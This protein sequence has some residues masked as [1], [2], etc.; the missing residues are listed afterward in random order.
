MAKR[1]KNE[2]S[3]DIICATATPEGAAALAVIRLSGKGSADLVERLME[4]GPGRLKG[5]RRKTGLLKQGSSVLDQVVALGWPEGSSYTGEEMVEIICHGVPEIVRSIMDC[6]MDRGARK[7]EPGE[8]TRRAYGSGRLSAWQVMA[9]SALWRSGDGPNNMVGNASAECEE[10]LRLIAEA[11]EKLEAEIEFQEEHSIGEDDSAI[12]ILESLNESMKNFRNRASEMETVSRVVL[13]GPVNSGKSTLFNVLAGMEKALVSDEPG[14][15]R[16]GSSCIVEMR[17]RRVLLC[18]SA[19]Y[20]GQGLDRK[21]YEAVIG[22]MEGT[23]KIV[24]LSVG[25]DEEPPEEILGKD[26][27]IIR[28]SSKSDLFENSD[29]THV[30]HTLRVSS[31]TGEGMGKLEEFISSFPGSM[32]VT[33][34]AKRIEKEVRDSLEYLLSGDYSLAAEHLAEAENELRAITARGDNVSLSVERAL[35][36][37]CVGK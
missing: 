17:G 15:T 33:G 18:D 12:S 4:L 27:E 3:A 37:M 36:S 32:S 22:N 31:V 20:G 10:L 19:G 1:S 29:G 21:A 6:L 30:E 23:E 7:A 8:F 9:L 5:K 2:T 11:R 24:W 16:D 13:M 25:G 14:T 26:A 35:S 28:V 34:A